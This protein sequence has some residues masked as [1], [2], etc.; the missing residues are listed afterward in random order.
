MM[1]EEYIEQ[2]QTIIEKA[3]SL[4]L[5]GGKCVVDGE[6]VLDLMDKIKESLPS[7]LGQAKAIVADRGEII[8]T[9][10]RE[11]DIIAKNAEE[12]AR[13]LVSKDEIV[14]GAE[15]KS[16]E[17]LGKASASANETAASANTKAAAVIAKANADAAS[18]I[19]TATNQA[20][21]VRTATSEFVEK[22]M[23]TLND[24]LK[25]AEKSVSDAY[26]NYQATLKTVK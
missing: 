4:P 16:A 3:W 11:A 21:Q 25:G 20:E 26:V 7:E 2:L 17:I 6:T 15:A 19:K 14:R 12:K 23:K 13:I 8:A 1:T 18:M 22:S 24:A 5:S 10:K 9:A